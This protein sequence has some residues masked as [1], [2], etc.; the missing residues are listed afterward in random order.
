MRTFD[1]SA[2]ILNDRLVVSTASTA[3]A[4]LRTAH[5]APAAEEE[6]HVE[7]TPVVRSIGQCVR[8][9]FND[10]LGLAL[11]QLV[12]GVVLF[13]AMT[14]ADKFSARFVIGAGLLATPLAAVHLAGSP[15]SRSLLAL[16][17]AHDVLVVAALAA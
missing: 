3:R 15:P 12:S 7:S 1:V 9:R 10:S 11:L 5:D 2:N 16:L 14:A 6:L 17:L 4:K 13:S 8:T